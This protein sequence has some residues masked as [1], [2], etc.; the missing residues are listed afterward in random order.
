MTKASRDTGTII[1]L[2]IIAVF[3]VVSALSSLVAD[4]DT[5][6]G[7]SPLQGGSVVSS[8]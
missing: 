7:R 5:Y 6:I 8:V 3:A 4:Y 2:M 1:S